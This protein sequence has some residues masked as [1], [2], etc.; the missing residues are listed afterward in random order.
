MVLCLF[1]TKVE[2]GKKS[3][4][5]I[6]RQNYCLLHS[7]RSESYV[8]IG[9]FVDS[10]ALERDEFVTSLVYDKTAHYKLTN[11]SS[12]HSSLSLSQLSLSLSLAVR[13]RIQYM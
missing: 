3:V 4:T 7:C 9:S 6:D 11:N 1:T 12:Q 10:R 5:K 13:R 8:R 2:K